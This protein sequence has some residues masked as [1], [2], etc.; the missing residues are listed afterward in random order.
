MEVSFPHWPFSSALLLGLFRQGTK[1]HIRV[2]H[3][4]NCCHLQNHLTS[5]H[6]YVHIVC[7]KHSRHHPSEQ[8]RGRRQLPMSR[9]ADGS[10]VRPSQFLQFCSCQN[11]L[12]TA[13]P[14]TPNCSP[15]TK[16]ILNCGAISQ[17]PTSIAYSVPTR[18]KNS[19]P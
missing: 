12:P 15:L 8:R 17:L 9:L 2:L 1:A 14:S 18:T 19:L 10:A 5:V 4:S 11:P 3:R 6:P 16:S 7:S 13:I